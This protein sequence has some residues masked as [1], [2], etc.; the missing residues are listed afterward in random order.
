MASPSIIIPP[1]QVSIASQCPQEPLRP[2]TRASPPV[3]SHFHFQTH[4]HKS[5]NTHPPT[6]ESFPAVGSRHQQPSPWHAGSLR[7]SAGQQS[8]APVLSSPFLPLSK[9][10][11]LTVVHQLP[12]PPISPSQP[13]ETDQMKER[14]QVR[15]SAM[16]SCI[17]L[18]VTLLRGTCC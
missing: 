17:D 5:Y 18:A 13:Q 15:E 1:G 9:A 14:C 7:R 4:A 11:V 12:G 16:T 6:L 2:P 3:K 10:K 8:T